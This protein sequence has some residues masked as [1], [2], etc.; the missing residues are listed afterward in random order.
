MNINSEN[1]ENPIIIDLG[2]G[3]IKAGF[4]G[5]DL[6]K[7][8]FNSFIGEPKYK[9]L[10]KNI[11]KENKISNEIYIGSQCDKNLNI[12]K[13]RY[14]IEHGHFV[15]EKDIYPIFNYIFSLLKISSEEIKYHPILITEPLQNPIQNRENISQILFEKFD[16]N[17]LFFA[18]QPILSL[19]STSNT[20]GTILE[21][22]E[23][24]S[25]SCV[26]YEGYS[27]PNSFER[28]DY[29]GA[30]VSNYLDDIL[31]KMGYFFETSAEKILIKDIKE[32][33]CWACPKN[34]LENIKKNSEFEKENHFLPDGNVMK[35]GVERIYPPEILF[36]PE[37]V[38]LEYPGFHEMIFNT[39]NNVNIELR[40]K[41]FEN[42]LLSGG[43]TAING[44]GNY[45]YSEIKKM[46]NQNVKINIH[47]PKNPHLMSWIGGNVVTGLEIFK[48]MWIT[49]KEW[50]EKGDII[51]HEKTI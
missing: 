12:L 14:P 22:G 40:T 23:G 9:K 25:Q 7:I 48:K 18:S 27:I 44:I 15:N 2:S 3:Q 1:S 28:C 21:S 35:L 17:K 11:N 29:G 20:T 51:L 8:I 47:S 37:I 19:F 39:I 5:R 34:I 31:K 41:L 38:G 43:N 10:I 26:I 6:P 4:G 24:V 42:I 30:D 45:V 32:K 13:L 36:K 46:V 16:I 50:E 33:Y 49:K